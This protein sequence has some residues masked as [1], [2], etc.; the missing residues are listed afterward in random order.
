MRDDLAH[1]VQ[2]ASVFVRLRLV[3][4]SDLDEL[5]WDDNEGFRRTGCRASQD[6]QALIHLGDSECVSIE[7]TPFVVGGEL[8]SSYLGQQC[9]IFVERWPANLLGA[10]IK[11]GAE[12]PLYNLPNLH[13]VSRR[14]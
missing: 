8:G 14:K 6:G 10:S 12:M 11:I 9:S 7:L 3:L 1:A 4:Q 13:P 5:E 2:H